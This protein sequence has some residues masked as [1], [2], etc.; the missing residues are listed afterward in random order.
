[1]T[2][3]FIV[4]ASLVFASLISATSASEK[5][6]AKT[7]IDWSGIYAGINGGYSWGATHYRYSNS[8]DN[9]GVDSSKNFGS[10]IYG[11]EILLNKQVG[12]LVFGISS[13]LSRI[14]ADTTAQLLYRGNSA[15]T[16]NYYESSIRSFSLTQLRAGY[17]FDNLLFSASAGIATG[18]WSYSDR[19]NAS[20]TQTRLGLALGASLDYAIT[21]EVSI[22]AKFSHMIFGNEVKLIYY[23]DPNNYSAHKSSFSVF[24][25]GLK[26][27]FIN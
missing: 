19:G 5:R 4:A 13:G 17:A 14:S 16:Y 10:G 18:R 11:A 9:Y 2:K 7:S 25:L 3:F 27:K 22:D 15:P 8:G 20:K 24:M 21:K 1:M 23:N 26:Y 12:S 6:E